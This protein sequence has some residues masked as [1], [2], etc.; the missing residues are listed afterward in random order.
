MVSSSTSTRRT[1]LSG[2]NR[3]DHAGLW[4][5]RYVEDLGEQGSGKKRA[6]DTATGIV[7]PKHYRASFRLWKE[8]LE[9]EGALLAMGY[10]VSS[11]LTAGADPAK[12]AR[13][14]PG[15]LLVGLGN[16]SILETSI[17]LHRTY[18]VPVIPGSALKGLA[19]S[20]AMRRL[21]DPMWC[22]SR[23]QDSGRA[24][25][26][27]FGT[28]RQAGCVTF[29]DALYEPGSAPHPLVPDVLTVHHPDYYQEDNDPS[30]PAD[31]DSPNPI[32]F[33][34]AT[35]AF[36]FALMGPPIWV[37]RAFEILRLALLE[38]GVGAKTT[39]G[40]GR[41]ALARLEAPGHSTS[42][43]SATA[44]PS[45][46]PGQSATG[47]FQSVSRVENLKPGEVKSRIGQYVAQCKDLS[48]GP[49]KK[50][51]A[52][53]I[54]DCVARHNWKDARSKPWYSE[55]SSFLEE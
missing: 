51:L 6:L 16:E 9:R 40:Y 10:C 50:A 55:I 42:S 12:A 27:V 22:P 14:S 24:H 43:A 23:E 25:K 45:S 4:L 20:F 21:S 52:R 3:A 17:T 2:V 18:G 54:L 53:A 29:L 15:R 5:D 31:W 32:P 36:L 44:S 34:T 49:E 33:L 8:A 28:Q 41:I 38:E 39:R 37:D 47:S 1:A 35:G 46:K 26:A 19:A 7:V 13:E 30:P 11:G 48:A